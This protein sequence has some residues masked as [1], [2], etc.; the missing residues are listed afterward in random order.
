MG[1]TQEIAEDA[2]G[3][4]ALLAPSGTYR[5]TTQGDW[6][7]LWPTLQSVIRH[8]MNRAPVWYVLEQKT[9]IGDWQVLVSAGESRKKLD[10]IGQDRSC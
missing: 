6:P 4:N 2:Q 5:I 9:A 1:A 10:Y 8:I 7:I 3:H